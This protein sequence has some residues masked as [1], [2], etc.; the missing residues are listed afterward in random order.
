MKRARVDSAADAACAS[1]GGSID[2]DV[3][4][5]AI[6]EPSTEKILMGMAAL[7]EY[8]MVK[9][10]PARQVAIFCCREPTQPTLEALH[11]FLKD[12]YQL[13]Q[14]TTECNVVA[15]MLLIRFLSYQPELKL[16][17]YTWQRFLITALLIAQKFWDD[18]CLR[19]VDFTLAWKRVLPE[20]DC[21]QLS[22][23]NLME[24]LFLAGLGYELVIHPTKYMACYFELISI[25]QSNRRASSAPSRD[26]PAISTLKAQALSYLDVRAAR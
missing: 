11:K 13:C 18:R 8:M 15:L 19:N 14:Y 21:V 20:A 7:L 25:V 5:A 6:E 4:L 9:I 2:I 10:Q 3:A 1:A 12:M 16:T 17:P 24:R 26:P 23:L 22:E